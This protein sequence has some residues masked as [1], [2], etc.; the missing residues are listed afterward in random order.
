L[1]K[2]KQV[3]N[4]IF[5]CSVDHDKFDQPENHQ[6]DDRTS[7]TCANLARILGQA[8]QLADIIAE[9]QGTRQ[10]GDAVAYST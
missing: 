4:S 1:Y 9:K 6:N 8:K 10:A 7:H 2:G 3:K 5:S